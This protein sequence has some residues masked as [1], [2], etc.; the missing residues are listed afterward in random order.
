MAHYK[1]GESPPRKP[2]GIILLTG[3]EKTGKTWFAVNSWDVSPRMFFANFD[4]SASHLI[5]KYEG[6]GGIEYEEF[7][8]LTKQQAQGELARL[9]S[10]KALA[11]SSG[12]G[13]FLLDNG[14]AWWDLIKIAKNPDNTGKPIPR[15]FAEANTY[16][17]DFM[18]TL[19]RSGLWVILTSPPRE[20]WTG[21]R[22]STGLFKQA[23]WGHID[24]HI[25][26]EIWLYTNR[27]VG[28]K[29]Q[30]VGSGTLVGDME[31]PQDPQYNADGVLLKGYPQ[32]EFKAQIQ[33]AAKRMSLNGL[34]M[35]DPTLAK[36]LRAMK[37]IE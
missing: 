23:G 17:R 33:I 29:P 27:P 26:S 25:M 30:P 31:L 37:E 19:E 1:P 5:E 18:L 36:M 16:A 21:S 10:L 6:K 7:T 2:G 34:I 24:F 22:T 11:M 9:D 4:R 3:M 13:V 20:L 32:L 35:K 14:A 15:E 28:A 12:S 8:A